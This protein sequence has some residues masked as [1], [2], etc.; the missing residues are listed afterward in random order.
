VI[1][2][3]LRRRR[4]PYEE[5]IDE[6]N[7]III[8]GAPVSSEAPWSG[9]SMKRGSTTSSSSTVSARRTSGRTWPSAGSPIT[10]T[11]DEF[12]QAVRRAASAAP[13][14]PSSTWSLLVDDGA[15]CRLP[16]AQQTTTTASKSR[17]GRSGKMSASS[18]P[19]A[20]PPTATVHGG[21]QT[22]TR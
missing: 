16:D 11:K 18:M 7:L 17:N 20:P 6:E 15:G 4:R 3:A 1:S 12:L 8:T 2:R 5:G 13:F 19:A 10:C 21:F 14:Q 9:N 22:T